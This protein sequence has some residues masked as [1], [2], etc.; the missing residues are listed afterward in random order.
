MRIRPSVHFRR[1]L[2][3]KKVE[4]KFHLFI[5]DKP[6]ASSETTG[7]N[8]ERNPEIMDF[9]SQIKSYLSGDV[10]LYYIIG[11]ILLENVFELYLIMR[12]VSNFKDNIDVS[13]LLA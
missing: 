4:Y 13:A 7:K 2:N 12:Q 1:H 10:I 6:F 5:V 11:F 8:S 9:T 3:Q